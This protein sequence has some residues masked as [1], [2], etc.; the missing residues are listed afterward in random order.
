M[1]GLNQLKQFSEDIRELGDETRIRSLRGE[2]PVSVPLPEGISEDDDSDDFIIGIPEKK[3]DEA[4]TEAAKPNFEDSMEELGSIDDILAGDSKND[5]ESLTSLDSI[6]DPQINADEADLADFLNDSLEPAPAQEPEPTPLE[7]MDLES[8]LSP[9]EPEAEP[10]KDDSSDTQ[11]FPDFA[12]EMPPAQPADSS[13][14][15][16][17]FSELGDLSNLADMPKLDD[18][19][20]LAAFGGE[21]AS[22][23][24]AASD[25]SDLDS[26]PDIDSFS[27]GGETASSEGAASDSS[28]LDSMPDIDSFSLGGETASSESTPSNSSDLDSLADI[29]SMPDIDSFSLGGDSASAE[30]AS[31]ESD[32]SDSLKDLSDLDSLD[33]ESGSDS[34]SMPDIDSFS[35]DSTGDAVASDNAPSDLDSLSSI[36]D[37][38]AETGSESVLPEADSLDDISAAPEAADFALDNAENADSGAAAPSADSSDSS[39]SAPSTDSSDSAPSTD[40]LASAF[41]DMDSLDDFGSSGSSDDSSSSPLGNIDFDDLVSGGDESFG[42]SASEIPDAGME[43]PDAM[44]SVPGETEEI[45]LDS[46]DTSDMDG[47]DFG[48]SKPI[49]GDEFPATDEGLNNDDD[50]FILDSNFEIP[51]FSDTETADMG[52]KKPLLD[53]IDFSKGREARP[54]NSLTDEEYVQFKKNLANYPLNLRIALEDFIARDEFTD[55]AVFDIIEKV[56]KKTS[57]RQLATQLEKILDISINIPRDFERRSFA[58]YEAYK[59][60]F[61]YQLKN[62]IIPAAIV[63]LILAFVCFGLFKAGEY[64]IYKPVMANI[65]Y[66]QGYTLIEA[67]EFPQSEDEFKEAVSYRPVKKWFFKYAMGYR[68][69]KQFERAGQMYKNILR[70]FNHDKQAGLEYA[71]ME[72]FDRANYER[73]EEIVRREVLDYHINDADGILMLGDV[74][75][76]WAEVEP[77][78]YELAKQQYLDLIQRYGGNDVYLSRM[79]RYNIR[80]DKL[81][82]VLTYKNMFFMSKN[83]KENLKKLCA[84]DWTELSGYL[85]EKLYG[86]LSKN[87]EYL[88]SSI[89]DV[90]EMLNLAIK[91]DPANPVARYNLARYFIHNGNTEQAKIEFER[92]LDLFDN[93]L[94]R[95]KKNVYREINATRILGEIYASNREY[96]KA[97]TIY[98]RGINLYNEEHEG[99]DLEGDVNTGKL[100]ADMG[101]LDY[102]VSGELDDA[103]YNYEK[104]IEI[105]N[106]TPSINFRVGSIYYGRKNYDKALEAFIKVSEKEPKNANVLLSLGNVLSLRGDNFAA[107]SYYSDLLRVL[108]GTHEKQKILLPQEDDEDYTLVDLYL[109]ANNNLGVTLYRIAHQTGNSSKNA[110]A[111]VRLSDSIRAWDALTRNPKTMIRMEGS[112]L[113][114]QNS[115]YITHPYPDF[116]PAIYTDIPRILSGEKGLE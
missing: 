93:L 2:K 66:K 113:A 59:Q 44:E 20:D 90:L 15:G 79:L 102:F 36:D 58:E 14:A 78:K 99:S 108:D 38:T 115:K 12:T 94:V 50:D 23:E 109:K 3:S 96:L 16:D 71:E 48:P 97:Q 83:E 51:G 49:S 77:S 103:L 67:N 18:A 60:S 75:L 35:L 41:S 9:S 101:D 22:S 61:Q 105:K 45:A 81:R 6:L 43:V 26:M 68:N 98:T 19:D 8:L 42:D 107:E 1:P 24:D 85:L 32:S 47:V 5:S 55:D 56:L 34:L 95:S 11:D 4:E 10:A 37:L 89:E 54:K 82:D 25:S 100:F 74:F 33:A 40:D 53:T 112:N 13:A 39:D 69:K 87:D 88:R 80:T 70:F 30:T 63:G 72:L 114:A 64:F 106:D 52:K 29:D 86:V 31:S 104:A 57:A 17:V 73:A 21:T 111:I 27:L 91:S 92:S 110:E 76:E 7:D 62:R 116:E 84:S 28:D 65:H 46:Y